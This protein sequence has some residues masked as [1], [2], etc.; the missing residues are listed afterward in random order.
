LVTISICWVL[1]SDRDGT[2]P[3][4]RDA[5]LQ[6]WDRD[7]TGG[8]D[9]LTSG[10]T[11][12]TTGCQSFTVSNTDTDAGGT[13]D[14]YFVVQLLHGG[15]YRVT[16]YA[17]G[18]FA[19]QTS[20]V[21]NIGANHGFGTWWIGG[22]AGNDR[23][24][25]IFND[26][27]RSRRFIAEHAINGGMGGEPGF[28]HVLW[29]TGGTDGTYY[30]L[31]DQKVHLADADAASRDTVVHEAAHR[32]MHAVYAAFPP[33]DC[34][35]PHFIDGVSGKYCGWTEGYTYIFVAGADGNPTY[36]WPSGAALN[37]ESPNCSSPGWDDG[38]RVEGRVGGLLIDL[39]DPFEISFGSVAGFG[40]E[41]T[42]AGCTGRDRTSGF[43]DG[44]WDL[45]Y[46]QD[47]TVVVTLDGVANSFSNA[48]E[49]RQYPRYAPHLAGHHNTIDSF[50]HD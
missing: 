38:P 49:S 14:V 21:Y 37:L 22:G 12:Y 33:G 20:V 26:L 2:T 15:R 8:D 4:L 34:P 40:N 9:L 30:S 41:G 3:P 48:W 10:Y 31:G 11:N 44:I 19:G 36:T 46:D 5:Y 32:Y 27:Y 28:V 43:F 39:A 24:V 50:T 25:R 45:I 35:S 13:I 7:S 6:L 18:T 1:G 47:D 23:S 29:E 17:G 16:N 42:A